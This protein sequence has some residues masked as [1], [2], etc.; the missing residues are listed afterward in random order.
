MDER[1]LAASDRIAGAA[2]VVSAGG[3]VLAMAHHPSGAHGGPL[4]S[5]V[6]GTMIVLLTLAAF[7]FLHWVRRRGAGRPLML[8]GLLAYL[9][10]LFGHVGAAMINGFVVPALAARGQEGVGHGIFLAAWEANQAMARL[11]VFAT[12]AA[13]ALWAIELVRRGSSGERIMGAAGLAAGL[14]PAALLAA[15]LIRMN[16]QGAFIVY[17][18]Q[19]AWTAWVG[20]SLLRV[21]RTVVA[22]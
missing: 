9:I 18:A 14:V 13:Y 20:L 15:G 19:V 12:S 8:A 10:S 4:G 21:R 17:A 22:D 6:H 1:E 3:T 5:I 2:M 11:G 7:G 16:V